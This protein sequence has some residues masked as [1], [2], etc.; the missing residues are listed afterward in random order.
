MKQVKF[1]LDNLFRLSS[2]SAIQTFEFENNSAEILISTDVKDELAYELHIE[3][4]EGKSFVILDKGEK[5]ISCILTSGMLKVG[6]NKIQLR[7]IGENDYIIESNS[8][9]F[10]VRSFINANVEPTPEE[11]TAFER[12]VVKVNIIENDVEDLKGDIDGINRELE[13]KANKSDIPTKTSELENDSDFVTS[14]DIP[15]VPT[16]TSQLTNDSGFITSR[17]IPTIPTKTSQLENDSDFVTKSELPAVPTKTSQLENDSGFVTQQELDSKMEFYKLDYVGG[18][19]SHDGVVLNYEQIIEKFNDNKY[20]LYAEGDGFVYIP[21]LPPLPGDEIIE[22]SSSYIYGGKNYMSRIIINSENQV[23]WEEIEIV[24]ATDF[25]D[26]QSEVKTIEDNKVSAITED[27]K[28]STENYPSNKAMTDY[29]AEHGGSGAIKDVRVG[30]TSA[31][32]SNGNVKF[33]PNGFSVN[34]A[35]K[36]IDVQSYRIST[37]RRNSITASRV[38]VGHYLDEYVRG[39]MCDGIGPAWTEQEQAMAQERIGLGD[40]KESVEDLW[41]LSKDISY[42]VTNQLESGV[43]VAPKGMFAESLLDVRGKSEQKSTNGYQMLDTIGHGKDSYTEAGVTYTRQSDGSY[44]ANGVSTGSNGWIMGAYSSQ[45]ILFT[46]PIGS[47]TLSGAIGLYSYDGTT[48]QSFERTF[49]LTEPLNVTGVLCVAYPNGTTAN[50]EHLYPM[51]EKGS[52]AHEWEPYTGGIP[53]PNPDYPQEITSVEEINFKVTGRNLFNF[54]RNAISD[55][56][57][58]TIL[59]YKEDGTISIMS[60]SNW[61]SDYVFYNA[62]KIVRGGTYI[63]TTLFDMLSK[64]SE[65]PISRQGLRVLIKCL[66]SNGNDIVSR[67][68]AFVSSWDISSYNTHYHAY[69]IGGTSES[70][71][72]NKPNVRTVTFT[73]NVASVVLGFCVSDAES[74]SE[75][76]FKYAQFER[77]SVSTQYEPYRES[78]KQIIPPFALNKI[79]EY[80]DSADID[81]GVW[82]KSIKTITEADYTHSIEREPEY[83]I[84]E[85]PTETPISA[86]DL[87]YLKSLQKLKDNS[88][89]TITDPNGNDIS[90]LMEYIIKLSEVN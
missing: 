70:L 66:D 27:N 9:E 42:K 20:F 83:F 4:S 30:T 71:E 61:G 18:A 38:L 87:E 36:I 37:D 76:I 39:A 88:V 75:T 46:L 90:F 44:I 80:Y 26:L 32:D 7:G 85:T 13:N 53:S 81:K 23:K 78:T 54:D 24:R 84:L 14:K 72:N 31:I 19:L 8:A 82:I 47:Y 51:L 62:S 55:K 73:N 77:G 79:G 58:N 43:N 40:I 49:T 3:N 64:R 5:H 63:I 6:V 67:E 74:N 25:K 15:T 28:E 68:S 34:P 60:T 21:T 52:V 2:I 33:N 57:G 65:S 29:V 12:L 86:T 16:R 89:I 48:R 50:N 59:N 56:W 69:M 22:F 11:Q 45:E 1:N 10:I 17:D 35:T 41:L